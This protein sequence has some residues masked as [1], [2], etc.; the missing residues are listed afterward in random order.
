VGRPAVV[1]LADGRP[2]PA[3]GVG[4][5]L[6]EIAMS[7]PIGYG[8]SPYRRLGSDWSGLTPPALFS[9]AGPPD[10]FIN[11]LPPDVSNRVPPPPS[12]AEPAAR[13]EAAARESG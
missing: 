2:S 7:D 12:A 13:E 5:I 11:L 1:P 10:W 6:K 3:P 8:R 4:S 9:M